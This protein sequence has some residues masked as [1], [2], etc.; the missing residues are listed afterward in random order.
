M[1]VWEEGDIL[2]VS[3]C[4]R[5]IYPFH[6]LFFVDYYC[7][8]LDLEIFVFPSISLGLSIV[9]L[10]ARN[11]YFCFKERKKKEKKKGEEEKK[12]KKKA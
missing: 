3:L 7:S 4:A 8:P 9:S 10:C 6:S 1:E 11:S 12:E 5:N 2:I